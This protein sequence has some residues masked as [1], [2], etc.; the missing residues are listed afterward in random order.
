[1]KKVA[2]IG[3]GNMAQALAVGFI[4]SKKIAKPDIFAYA[5][6][7]EKLAKNAKK[8]GFVPCKSLEEAVDAADT[9]VMACKPYQIEEVVRLAK[10][11][12]AKLLFQL[13]LAGTLRN[14]LNFL[15]KMCAFSS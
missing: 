15:K 3:M 2:F 11:F 7:Q 1:M 14:I 5:P 8:M 10:N 9:V 6:N 4:K 12:R 13:P